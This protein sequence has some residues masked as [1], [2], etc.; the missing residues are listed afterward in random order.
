M[1]NEI[2]WRSLKVDD[3]Y[4]VS[5]TGVVRKKGTTLQYLGNTIEVPGSTLQPYINN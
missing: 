3:R 1:V 2:I 5:N 4:E